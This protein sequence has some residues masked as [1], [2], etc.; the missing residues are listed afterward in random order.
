MV[1][2]AALRAVL[3]VRTVGSS[4][5][6]APGFEVAQGSFSAGPRGH[7]SPPRVL[8]VPCVGT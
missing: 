8:T 2:S 4:T 3:G 6:P 7:V 5:D 1:S